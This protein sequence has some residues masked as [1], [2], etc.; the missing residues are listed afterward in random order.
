VGDFL[1]FRRMLTPW[2]VQ[3]IFWAGLVAIIVASIGLIVAGEPVQQVGGVFLLLLGPFVLRI[4]CEFV[5][6]IFR[7]NESLTDIRRNTRMGEGG[8]RI[9]IAPQPHTWQPPPI[10]DEITRRE[11]R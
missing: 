7:I 9:G 4:W 3:A 6:V 11:L 1:A 8:N 5:I 10:A 2:L